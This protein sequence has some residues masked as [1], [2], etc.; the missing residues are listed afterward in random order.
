MMKKTMALIL[1]LAMAGA[2]LGAC[3]AAETERTGQADGYG[4]PLRV[5]VTLADGRIKQVRVLEQHETDGV[6]SRA[7]EALPDRMI[8]A[9]SADVDGVSGATVTSDALREAVRRAL[10]EAPSPEV[11]SS[12]RADGVRAGVGLCATGRIGPGKDEA[13]KPVKTVNIVAA[14]ALFDDDDR[15]TALRIDQLEA[16]APDL[17][18]ADE[19]F[20]AA[21]SAWDTKGMRGEAYRLT[22]GTWREEMDAFERLFTGM[23]ADEVTAW[24]AANCSDETGRPLTGEGSGADQAK[25]AAMSKTQQTAL[26]DVTSRAT[27]SLRD[28]HGD[29]ITAIRRAWD[30][31]RR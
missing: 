12:P 17:A 20:L 15:I 6:G 9:N 5:S 13:G 31:A 26:A 4:G 19:A 8:A 29:I 1:L 7:I 16:A 18:Q 25:Y 24:F 22:S 21:V 30:D 23:T 28:E 10:A 27:M 11:S 3:A 2:I 14:S